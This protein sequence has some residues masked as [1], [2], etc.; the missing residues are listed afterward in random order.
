MR[1]NRYGT[2]AA[3]LVSAMFAT[4]L[5]AQDYPLKP[6]RIVVPVPP[7]GAN[8]TL[9]RLIAPRLAEALK[10]PVLIDNRPGGSTTI[11]TAL[12][13][14]SPPDGYVLLMAPSAHTVNDT[15][16]SS[17]PYDPIRDFTPVATIAG[18][19]LLLCVHPSLP[20]RNVKELVALARAKPGQLNYASAGNGTSSHLAAELFKSVTAT[21]IVHVPYKGGVAAAADVVGGHVLMMFGTVQSSVVY[22]NAKR[23]RALGVTSARRSALARD[24]PTLAEAGVQG[25]EVGSWF[26]I[27]G[28]AGL[29]KE[30]VDRL[31][32]EIRRITQT[33]EMRDRMLGL[34]YEIMYM[35]SQPFAA[36]LKAD[37]ARWSKVIRDAGIRLE[38]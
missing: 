38:S 36:F 1:G 30:I 23:L 7:G 13:A 6:I 33:A 21:T 20:V 26:G 10:Q 24:I 25:L 11:G 28:P 19:P 8:D 31:D 27:V 12:V 14:K 22:V 16:F 3:A 18:A 15:L 5:L 34:G 37:R 2:A 9:T 17:L 32:A 29:S 35:S 4:C